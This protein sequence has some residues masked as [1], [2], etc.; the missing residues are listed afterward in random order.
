MS[1]DGEDPLANVQDGVPTSHPRDHSSLVKGDT[2]EISMDPKSSGRVIKIGK[3]LSSEEVEEHFDLLHSHPDI[4]AWM[5]EEI[6]N[7]G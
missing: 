7:I 6:P 4:F 5:Y 3:F 1:V 2:I